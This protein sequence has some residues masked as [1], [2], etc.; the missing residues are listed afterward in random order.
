M[1]LAFGP[2]TGQSYEGIYGPPGGAYGEGHDPV[3]LAPN[4]KYTRMF[5]ITGNGVPG[6]HA[7]PRPIPMALTAM[8][9]AAQRC[10]NH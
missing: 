7:A 4:L 8:C 5:V 9:A 1:P 3:A 10:R 2:A 6:T